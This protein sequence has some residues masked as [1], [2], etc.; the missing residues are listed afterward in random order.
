MSMVFCRGCAK[1]ISS[2][3]VACPQCGAP[4]AQVSQQ[5]FTAPNAGAAQGNPYV[6]V[7]K[8]YAVF[9]GRAS[10]R[11]YWMFILINLGV[12]IVLGVI[13]AVLGAKGILSN[14]YS[15]AV[16]LPSI[17]AAIRR[18][19]DTDRSGWWIL[20]PIVNIVFLAQD[21]TPGVNRFGPNPK[22][23]N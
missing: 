8:K 9:T 4:Q 13:D 17:A 3:A 2:L 7:L 21:S 10:R 16:L 11:E 19:H 15:L 5:A 22:G 1:E 20:L 23:I 14:L 18:M 12:A 6:E